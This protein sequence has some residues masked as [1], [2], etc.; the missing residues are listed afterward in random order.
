MENW[1]KTRKSKNCSAAETM[2]Y[3]ERITKI[4]NEDKEIGL[5]AITIAGKIG[6]TYG[7][8][9]KYLKEMVRE[10]ILTREGKKKEGD[11]AW[12]YYYTIKQ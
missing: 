4:L 5:E 8:T 10:G 1:K 9:S 11:T 6:L 7:T 2:G 12:N 3:R